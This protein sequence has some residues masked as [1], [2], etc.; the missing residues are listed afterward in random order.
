M[1]YAEVF[2][3]VEVG[4]AYDKTAEVLPPG[5]ALLHFLCILFNIIADF[6]KGLK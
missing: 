5:E 3:S 4:Y 1:C 6:M 2:D